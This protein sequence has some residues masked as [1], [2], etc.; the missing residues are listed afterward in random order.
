LSDKY[1][2]APASVSEFGFTYDDEIAEKLGGDVWSGVKLAEEEFR[3][4]A[5]QSDMTPEEMR[6]RMRER[7]HQQM[8]LTLRLRTS[9]PAEAEA[10][11]QINDSNHSP[12]ITSRPNVRQ[13]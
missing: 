5:E 11:R 3:R 12:A 13:T 6:P 8:N 4:R 7:Y 10:S 9:H 1:K 2:I